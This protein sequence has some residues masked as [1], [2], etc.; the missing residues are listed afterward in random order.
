MEGWP[1]KE[2]SA[3][4]LGFLFLEPRPAP[5]FEHGTHLYKKEQVTRGRITC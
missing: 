3:D 5:E 2:N 1:P 4:A